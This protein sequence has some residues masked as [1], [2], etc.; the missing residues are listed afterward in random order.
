MKTQK[1]ETIKKQ[2]MYNELFKQTLYTKIEN[3]ADAKRFANDIM[4]IDPVFH[5]S[6][7]RDEFDGNIFPIETHDAI[8]NRI[9]EMFH[10]I[11]DEAFEIALAQM[12]INIELLKESQQS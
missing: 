5:F 6:D 10:F 2:Q 3:V 7:R 1:Q 12:E 9:D 8:D 4:I 11:G